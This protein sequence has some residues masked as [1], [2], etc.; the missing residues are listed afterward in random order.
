MTEIERLQLA[1]AW[2]RWGLEEIGRRTEPKAGTGDRLIYPVVN[3]AL[4]SAGIP[5][6]AAG[7]QKPGLTVAGATAGKGVDPPRDTA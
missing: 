5:A 2:L 1:N 4:H 3:E 6:T 7:I